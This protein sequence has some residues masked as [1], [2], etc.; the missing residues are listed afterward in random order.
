MGTERSTRVCL[1]RTPT[2]K[3]TFRIVL[4]KMKVANLALVTS[5]IS[6]SLLNN[7]KGTTHQALTQ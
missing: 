1:S 7:A 4:A 6:H 5:S 2:I 3:A